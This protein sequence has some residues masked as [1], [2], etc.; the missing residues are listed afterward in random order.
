[1]EEYIFESMDSSESIHLD[2]SHLDSV[3]MVLKELELAILDLKSKLILSGSSFDSIFKETDDLLERAI[4]NLNF[5]IYSK[6]Q[7]S[8]DIPVGTII[9]FAGK[10]IPE[11]WLECNGNRITETKYP[12]LYRLIGESLPN[13][14]NHYV[15]GEAGEFENKSVGNDHLSLKW[16]H[17]PKKELG[18][19][20]K[21]YD[22]RSHIKTN[23]KP[24][25]STMYLVKN[26]NENFQSILELTIGADKPDPIILEPN[27]INL[28]YLIK[29][30]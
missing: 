29:A 22:S 27:Y 5:H 17:L 21:N 13:L 6:H 3:H 7:E 28:I 26:G 4:T 16:D 23:N 10:N 19:G 12:I 15:M 1:M 20:V 18:I 2:V 25:D 24:N 11:G 30:F 9:S 8:I 14:N